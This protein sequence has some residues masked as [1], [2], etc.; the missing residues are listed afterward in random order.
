MIPR[1]VVCSIALAVVAVGAAGGCRRAEPEDTS[2]RP[3]GVTVQP[4]RV[5]TLR[6]VAM[7]SGTVVPAT[8]SDWTVYAQEA[9]EIVELPRKEQDQVA[10]GDLLV[11]FEIPSLTQELAARELAVGEATARAERA[12]AEET[13]ITQLFEKGIA[14][15]QMYDNARIEL[16]AAESQRGQAMSQ[17]EASKLDATRATVRARFP[18]TVVKVWR[19]V[20]ES[21]RGGLVDPIL[22]VVDTTRLQVAIELPIAQLARIVVGQAATV[23]AI[24]GD[25][26][27]AATVAQKANVIDPAA[28]TGQ[29]R[30]S[31]NEPNTLPAESPVSAEILIDQRTSAMIIPSS[32][33]QKDSLS[34]YVMVAGEDQRA[35]RQ[36]VVLG[37]ATRD[38]TQ[39]MSG[40]KTGDR[41]I[42]G[43]LSDVSEG[44]LISFTP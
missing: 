24:A 11:R 17:L 3:V 29:V 26:V 41:L 28:P 7:A 30:L 14:S 9:A 38:F 37:L 36:D 42:V 31:F 15:R 20:G 43:G 4:V 32:A 16:T 13:R 18:G 19:T 25:E 8:A 34:S 35:H 21:V 12:K 33:L 2:E 44:T 5:E 39:V 22:Q 23:R 1:H 6:D 40:V 10:T 27:L